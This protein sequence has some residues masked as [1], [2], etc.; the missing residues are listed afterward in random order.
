MKRTLI[1]V[2]V[3]FGLTAQAEL[4]CNPLFTWTTTTP[5][6]EIS[7]FRL[8]CTPALPAQPLLFAA[9]DTTWLAP[10]GTFTNNTLYTCEMTAV[11]TAGLES[12]RS[13]AVT[14]TQNNSASC[15]ISIILQVQ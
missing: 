3:A 13:N 7:E 10:D 9:S 11:D 1:G 12:P 14:F 2:L 15:N 8:Y 6:S 5:L 4:P